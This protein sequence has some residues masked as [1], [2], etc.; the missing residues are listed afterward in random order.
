MS[1]HKDA[2]ETLQT[3]E[4]QALRAALKGK[5]REDGMA[6]TA[7]FRGRPQAEHWA[8]A[9]RALGGEVW[10]VK[11]VGKM[12]KIG[13]CSVSL[14]VKMTFSV[15]MV[16]DLYLAGRETLAGARELAE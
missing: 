2:T 10:A 1:H 12:R 15:G 7:W 14:T 6:L 9:I 3:K 11:K 5:V 16:E 4:I 13:T 8:D